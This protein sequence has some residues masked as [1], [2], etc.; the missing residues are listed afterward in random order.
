VSAGVCGCESG[1]VVGDT[2]YA[3]DTVPEQKAEGETG[4]WAKR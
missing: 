4:L 1:G 3:G 2:G